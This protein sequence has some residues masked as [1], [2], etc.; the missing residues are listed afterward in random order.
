MAVSFMK[1]RVGFEVGSSLSRYLTSESEGLLF[2]Q[3]FLTRHFQSD[4]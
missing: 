2:N 3:C 4:I 1:V